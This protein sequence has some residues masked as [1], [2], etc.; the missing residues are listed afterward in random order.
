[1]GYFHA[2]DRYLQGTSDAGL[3]PPWDVQAQEAGRPGS[4]RLTWRRPYTPAIWRSACARTF[5]RPLPAAASNSSSGGRPVR[6]NESCDA[7]S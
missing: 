2:N 1:M 6:K 3:D 5:R 7:S 4:V